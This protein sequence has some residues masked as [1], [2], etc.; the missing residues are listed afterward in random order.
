MIS[1]IH[2]YTLLL[3]HVTSHSSKCVKLLYKD[4]RFSTSGL[5]VHCPPKPTIF[6]LNAALVC[7]ITTRLRLE[8]N[9]AKFQHGSHQLQHRLHLI[10]HEAH[11]LHGILQKKKKKKCVSWCR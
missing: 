9:V 7:T 3:I 10:V 1:I 11:N 4:Q 5:P 6:V 2:L 8:L